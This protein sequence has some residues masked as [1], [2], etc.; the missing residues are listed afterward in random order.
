MPFTQGRRTGGLCRET[1]HTQ[2][3]LRR[4]FSIQEVEVAVAASYVGDYA[5]V[6]C[7]C[8]DVTD[9]RRAR[10][11]LAESERRFSLKMPQSI[12]GVYIIQDGELV[13]VNPRLAGMFGYAKESAV[14]GC[15]VEDLVEQS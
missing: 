12:A 11:E 14:M 13:H 1:G 5:V 6:H 3:P 9:H 4:G 15:R 8:G 10:D 7:A 2:A